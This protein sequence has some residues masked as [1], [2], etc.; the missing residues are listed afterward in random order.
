[1]NYKTITYQIDGAVATITLNE[2]PLNIITIAMMQEIG[3]AIDTSIARAIRVIVFAGAGEK[4]FSA[5]VEISEHTPDLIE[6]MLT[7]FHDIFRKLTIA[8]QEGGLVTIAQVNGHCLGGGCELACFCDFVIA[9]ENSKFG[10]PEIMLGCYPP[11]A[12]ALFP[13]MIGRRPA[14]RLMFTGEI[15]DAQKALALGLITDLVSK[16]ELS[17]STKTTIASIT[18][19]SAAVLRLLRQSEPDWRTEFLRQLDIAEEVYLRELTQLADMEEGILAFQEKRK[20]VWK[21]R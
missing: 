9:T 12:A 11:V 13:A 14:E 8:Q 10:T 16:T 20:P 17:E 5:G 7:S 2:P 19:K 18:D 3:D 21:N 6:E 4:A 15:I 1:M